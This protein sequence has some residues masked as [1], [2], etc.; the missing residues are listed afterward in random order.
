MSRSHESPGAR[1]RSLWDRLSPLPGGHWLFTRLLG[2]MVPYAGT[3]RA[4]VV[5]LEPGHVRV[6]LP[7]RWRVRNHLRSVHAVALTNVGELSTGLALVT[8]LGPEAR[9]ILTHLETAYHHKARGL[10]EAEARCEVPTDVDDHRELVITA[11]V[12][13]SSDTVVS[14][15]HATW[16]VS[17]TRQG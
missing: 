17:P 4:I 13:D 10:L 1:I 12:R 9:A 11:Y 7:D 14:T 3:L 8:G 5:Q 16:R 15:T 6:C 2:L